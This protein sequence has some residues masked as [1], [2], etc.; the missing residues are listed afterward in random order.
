MAFP[1]NVDAFLQAQD[2][3]NITDIENIIVTKGDK[4]GIWDS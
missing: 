4:F 3:L 2:P 1:E